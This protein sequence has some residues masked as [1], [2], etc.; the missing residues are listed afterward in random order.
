MKIKILDLN[1]VDLILEIDL[2]KNLIKK[3][4]KMNMMKF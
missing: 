1:Q 2:I 4:I 3:H